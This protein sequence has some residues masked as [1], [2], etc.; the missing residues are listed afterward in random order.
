MRA[1]CRRE[2]RGCI[3]CLRIGPCLVDGGCGR[4]DSRFGLELCDVL[5]LHLEPALM[6]AVSHAR[7][8]IEVCI[9]VENAR[10]IPIA[11]P[12]VLRISG[13]NQHG[14]GF[15]VNTLCES[16]S[17]LFCVRSQGVSAMNRWGASQGG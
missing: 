2:C 3:L 14:L 7:K 9:I 11:E 16:T 15:L 5:R 1:R 17:D 10:L 12:I 4:S 8:P 6:K 13:G